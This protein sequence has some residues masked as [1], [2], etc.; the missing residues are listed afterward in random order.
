VFAIGSDEF[1]AFYRRASGLPVDRRFDTIADLAR[2]VRTHFDLEMGT[3]VLVANPIPPEDEMPQDVYER[4]L[5]SA[6]EAAAAQG[7]RGRAVTPF[8]LERMHAASGGASVRANV[9]LLR[10]N[11]R[12]AAALAVHLG[13]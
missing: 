11:A 8:L 5:G 9:A 12:V 6:L 4:A 13:R 10:N 2:A 3:G 1:P 7:V